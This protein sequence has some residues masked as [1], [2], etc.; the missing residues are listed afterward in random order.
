MDPQSMILRLLAVACPS[1]LV[2]LLLSCSRQVM[3]PPRAVAVSACPD[4]IAG[5]DDRLVTRFGLR[6]D[7]PSDR[8]RVKQQQRD[9]P[10]EVVYVARPNGHADAKLVISEDDGDFRELEVA[11]PT[12]SKHVGERTMR[13]AEGRNFGT[14]RW[15]YLQSGERWRQVRFSTGEHVGYKPL[16]PRQADLLDQIVSSACFARNE[17]LKR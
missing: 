15:G 9:M 11:Y 6:F 8:F 4:T 16:P 14:D 12:F 3:D 2:C 10:P 13:D 5:A 17:N 7:V 1:C